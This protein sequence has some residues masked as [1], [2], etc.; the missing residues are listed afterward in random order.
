[1]NRYRRKAQSFQRGFT[2]VELAIAT[3]VLLVGVVA[4]VQLVPAAIQS[5]LNNRYDTTSAVAVQRLRDLMVSQALDSTTLT[6]P[7]GQF[8]CAGGA[9]MLGIGAPGVDT[10][11]GSPVL[12]VQDGRGNNIDVV[13]NFTAARVPGYNF[14]FADLNDPTG[15]RYDVRWAVVTSRRAVGVIPDTVVAK[16]IIIGARRLGSRRPTVVTFS[17]W[18][19]R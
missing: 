1:V 11:E 3:L 17:S 7:S 12:A 6:D 8:P 19:T 13:I 10:L 9:C 14:T 5:N 15:T 18:V 4:V 16:R 2:L